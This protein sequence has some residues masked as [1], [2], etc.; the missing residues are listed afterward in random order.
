MAKKRARGGL[1]AREEDESFARYALLL[2][3][4]IGTIAKSATQ[5]VVVNHTASRKLI[6]MSSLS[7]MHYVVRS[8][9]YEGVDVFAHSWNPESAAFID[10]QYGDKLRAS[11]HQPV[12]TRLN[13]RSQSLSLARAARLMLAHEEARGRPYRLALAL[14]H[15]IVLGSAFDLAVM[16]PSQVWLPTLC[17]YWVRKFV[18]P[19]TSG[20]ETRTIKRACGRADAVD[21]V[22]HTRH[23]IDQ[24]LG[25]RNRPFPPAA[26]YAWFT[27][28]FWVAAAPATLA[29][30]ADIDARYPEYVR[31][32]HARGI[33]VGQLTEAA[34]YL[35]STHLHVFLN[36]TAAVRFARVHAIMGR[37][38]YHHLVGGGR[39]L[40]TWMLDNWKHNTLNCDLLRVDAGG[41]A[42]TRWVSARAEAQRM[43]AER[44]GD[45]ALQETPFVSYLQ[46]CQFAREP[47]VCCGT[48]RL[49]QPCWQQVCSADELSDFERMRSFALRAS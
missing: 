38:A 42:P 44:G 47:V 25:L 39:Q 10:Q 1:L 46:Q 43:A 48:S 3:G 27:N 21:I 28:D 4:R 36:A 19:H 29:T 37:Y 40:G 30:W 14:R 15:D 24:L 17:G 9:A 12:E 2:H 7:H 45:D 22:Y 26:N 5:N 32:L 16:A 8:N 34:H 20:F 33:R 6:V 31:A 11:S 35:W 18:A 49:K 13:G 23:R 41:G